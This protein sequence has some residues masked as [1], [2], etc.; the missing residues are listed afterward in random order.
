M[1][2]E[3]PYDRRALVLALVQL[4]LGLVWG[5]F[6]E[7]GGYVTEADFYGM[8][9]PGA[10]ALAAGEPYVYLRSGPGLSAVLAVL[11]LGGLE[12]FV[13]AKGVAALSLAGLAL[14]AYF[15]A[16]RCT[17]PACALALQALV[18]V[19][20]QRFA[21]VAGNDVPS[22]A[23]C[24][25]ALAVLARRERPGP[26]AA[27]VAGLFAGAAFVTR[28]S[29]LALLVAVT[30]ALAL[31]RP[32]RGA[33]RVRALAAF[34][35][36]ALLAMA[37]WLVASQRWFGQP[38][39]NRAYGLVALE[40]Y[41]PADRYD[42]HALEAMDA[43]FHSVS[44][45]LLH[46][47]AHTL[48]YY[49]RDFLE[50]ASQLLQD[51]VHFPAYLAVGLGIVLLCGAPPRRRWLLALTALFTALGFASTALVPYQARYFY[52][53]V[54]ALLWPVAA[55]FTLPWTP[56]A[57]RELRTP[58]LATAAAC[59]LVLAAGSAYKTHE[60]LTTE[61]VELL[62]AS[63]ALAASARPG[64]TL[65]ARKP[66]L[67]YLAGGLETRGVPGGDVERVLAHARAQGTRFLYV[68]PFEL[69]QNPRLAPLATGADVPPG[70]RL[71]H[72]HDAPDACLY[73]LE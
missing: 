10:H 60:Y 8:Y 3:H 18:Y 36:G 37:P 68:G 7:V 13:A 9:G 42:Q 15:V 58:R 23:L 43:R 57:G 31:V 34:S 46:D 24:W 53:L 25:A 52:A 56:L 11:A 30:L 70:L 5:A 59:V 19:V 2:S 66:H 35:A 40:L 41:G 48:R 47:P 27:G 33:E 17:P 14:A 64:D 12:P 55:A 71:L 20:L 39:N 29:G 50:D 54:P 44:E 61:P 4:A 26:L 67:G 21:F 65:L 22:A 63:E 32:W 62:A 72:R 51:V 1:A 28:Y 69:R 49:A 16:S 73:A 6:H 45:V 38:L